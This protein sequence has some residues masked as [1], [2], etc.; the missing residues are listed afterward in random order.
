[1]FLEMALKFES[2]KEKIQIVA[3]D[4]S[5]G[6]TL[7]QTWDYTDS[8]P[9]ACI[10]QQCFELLPS[11]FIAGFKD[12]VNLNPMGSF[13][14]TMTVIDSIEGYDIIRQFSPAPWGTGFAHRSTVSCKYLVEDENDAETFVMIV[15][16]LGN[17]HFERKWTEQGLFGSDVLAMN[18]SYWKVSPL[19]KDGVTHGSQI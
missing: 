3:E 10:E 2:E 9:L 11:T 13:G 16:S 17:E 6:F 18:F 1:M 5:K 15:S 8:S 19:K 14:I 7:R 4:D 12:W